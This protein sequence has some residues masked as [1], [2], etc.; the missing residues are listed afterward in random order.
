MSN[1]G[2]YLANLLLASQ[3][4]DNESYELFLRRIIPFLRPLILK[5]SRGIIS[6]DDAVQETLLA[7]HKALHTYQYPKSV[8]AWT[9]V[10]ARHKTIDLLRQSLRH[11]RSNSEISIDLIADSSAHPDDA[12][13]LQT[14]WQ[15][16]TPDEQ[17]LLV[18]V[19][20]N[21]QSYQEISAE[22]GGEVSALK[23][24]V[25]RLLKRLREYVI[26]KP[27]PQGN[28]KFT[29]PFTFF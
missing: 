22:F 9:S 12:I 8:Q 19:K 23:V 2:D 25:H 18:A 13:E 29:I 10:I 5:T 15:Q 11:T 28:S 6:T 27:S 7:I 26:L 21:G 4:G 17:K 20:I 14:L 24:R 16:L 3:Q 1:D